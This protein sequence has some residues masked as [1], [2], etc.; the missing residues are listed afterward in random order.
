MSSISSATRETSPPSDAA[1]GV[2]FTLDNDGQHDLVVNDAALVFTGAYQRSGD[3]LII[4][5]A[6]ES[7]TIHNYFKGS[8]HPNISAPDGSHLAG[9]VVFALT[10][11][12]GGS[13]Y[14]QNGS[15][16]APAGAAQSYWTS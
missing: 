4:S 11:D 12:V 5:R 9:D 2:R 3:D 6:F 13:R 10:L 16:A 7:A 15:P 8:D 14:A 1:F